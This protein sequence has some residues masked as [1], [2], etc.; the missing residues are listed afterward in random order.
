MYKEVAQ[1]GNRRRAVSYVSTGLARLPRDTG[2]TRNYR[3]RAVV[4][5]CC[6]E[7]KPPKSGC[8]NAI[9]T[10][11]PKSP[12]QNYLLKYF[13]RFIQPLFGGCLHLRIAI[14]K[15]TIHW[16]SPTCGASQKTILHWHAPTC[17]ASQKTA[18]VRF[19]M[20]ARGWPAYPVTPIAHA[21]TAEERL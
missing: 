13:P 10:S 17:G 16:Y 21:T 7:E 11:F 18:E 20:L 2:G 19:N 5:R 3:R 8:R 1:R 4:E 12:M 15:T 14:D 6:A 9:A